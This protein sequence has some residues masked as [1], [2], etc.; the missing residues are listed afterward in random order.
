MFVCGS[1][2]KF[3]AVNS[4]PGK[5]TDANVYLSSRLNCSLKNGWRPFTNPILLGDSNYKL[6]KFL[7]TPITKYPLTF[8]EYRYNLA[9][10]K[11]RK[12]TI[13][14]ALAIFKVNIFLIFI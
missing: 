10:E 11:T 8:P 13:L 5:E 9:I 2:L 14:K 3:F 4:D 7:M 1:N 12:Q 6:D